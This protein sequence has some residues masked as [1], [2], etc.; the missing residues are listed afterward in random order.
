M[1]MMMMT[2]MAGSIL[3]AST[4]NQ[5][6]QLHDSN[7]KKVLRGAQTLRTGCSKAEPKTPAADPLPRGAG[8]PKLNQLETVTTFTYTSSLVRID[9]R[10]S[11]LS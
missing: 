11:E 6:D 3:T 9:S 2:K 4:F 5:L 7:M 10:N 8:W 1:M